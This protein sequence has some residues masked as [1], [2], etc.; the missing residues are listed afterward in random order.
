MNKQ[1]KIFLYKYLNNASPT[2]FESSGQ[3]IW[4]DDSI[5]IK[6]HLNYTGLELLRSIGVEQTRER[7][8]F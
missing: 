5:G 3:Q 6:T 4:L 2:G 1:S 8:G 7:I